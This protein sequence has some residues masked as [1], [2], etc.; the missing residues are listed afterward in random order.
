MQQ[1]RTIL[2]NGLVSVYDG[3]SRNVKNLE[4]PKGPYHQVGKPR[5]KRG[6]L[7]VELAHPVAVGALHADQ[8]DAVTVSC[9][10]L[11]WHG[12]RHAGS[13]KPELQ[14]RCA[15][16]HLSC[17]ESHHALG[18]QAAISSYSCGGSTNP[19]C[20][21]PP[22][23]PN[24]TPTPFLSGPYGIYGPYGI[25]FLQIFNTVVYFP[26][27]WIFSFVPRFLNLYCRV[28]YNCEI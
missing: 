1:S 18:E 8:T 9:R 16:G 2:R 5:E 24:V 13:L 26:Y 10:S 21:P 19:A 6:A 20:P 11:R 27:F 17:A 23:P 22:A 14:A 4:N 7:A 15:G 12:E 25:F 28:L 3:S